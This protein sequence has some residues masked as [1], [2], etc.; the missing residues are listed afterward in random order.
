MKPLENKCEIHATHYG[1]QACDGVAE[2]RMNVSC[3]MCLAAPAWSDGLHK[4]PARVMKIKTAGSL[5]AA[6]GWRVMG[7]LSVA[8]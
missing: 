7:D 5:D 6:G 1:R 3:S 8:E 4:R 2:V